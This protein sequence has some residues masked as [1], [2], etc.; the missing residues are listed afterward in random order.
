MVQPIARYHVTL[1]G[2]IRPRITWRGKLIMQVEE[3]HQ[4][5][6]D[7]EPSLDPQARPIYKWRDATVFDYI[8]SAIAKME[9]LP[10]QPEARK[11]IYPPRPISTT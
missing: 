4:R 1:T 11:A 10:A 6:N 2:R 8:G 7:W 5:L 9:S 3:C